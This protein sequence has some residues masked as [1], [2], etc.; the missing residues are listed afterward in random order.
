MDRRELSLSYLKLG[1]AEIR[2]VFIGINTTLTFGRSSMVAA[3]P[4][5]LLISGG[6]LVALVCRRQRR[7]WRL[8]GDHRTRPGAE[9]CSSLKVSGRST[10]RLSAD[11][12]R[13]RDAVSGSGGPALGD[14]LSTAR[15]PLA[16]LPARDIGSARE[17]RV[18]T[19]RRGSG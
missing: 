9:P 3:V 12:S 19:E 17:L 18:A 8:D 14:H 1:P 2:L 15:Q 6:M 10:Q 16:D 4:P 7:L 5:V 11:Q 13:H